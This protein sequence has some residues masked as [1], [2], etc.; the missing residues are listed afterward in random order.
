M[1]PYA[2][3]VYVLVVVGFGSAT[4]LV[5]LCCPCAAFELVI[6]VKEDQREVGIMS[7]MF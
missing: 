3:S 6:A 5:N 4:W 2:R 1:V 7:S